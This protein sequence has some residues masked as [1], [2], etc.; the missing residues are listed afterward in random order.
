MTKESESSKYYDKPEIV[1]MANVFFNKGDTYTYNYGKTDSYAPTFG[2]TS[3][4]TPYTVGMIADLLH[5]KPFYKWHPEVVKALLLT[6]SV[7]PLEMNT[8]QQNDI[9][10]NTNKLICRGLPSYK[11]MVY[12]NRSRYWIGNKDDHFTTATIYYGGSY[13]SKNAIVFDEPNIT[14]G[15]TYRIAI[16]WLVDGNYVEENG[17]FP[18]DIDLMVSQVGTSTEKYSTSATNPFE[19]VEFKAENSNNL[20]IKIVRYHNNGNN[21]VMLGYNLYEV[22]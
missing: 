17:A 18:Q 22:P 5:Q 15:K 6:S 12:G 9:N 16:A 8:N 11:A 10:G 14:A 2:H 19:M 7:M 4:A 21:R 13:V 20:T 1:N 3:A